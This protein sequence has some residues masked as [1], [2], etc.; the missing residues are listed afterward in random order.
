MARAHGRSAANRLWANLTEVAVMEP[1]IAANR[2]LP[3]TNPRVRVTSGE[4]CSPVFGATS[5]AA[6]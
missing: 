4:F 3:I 6:K 2:R 5:A 1:I